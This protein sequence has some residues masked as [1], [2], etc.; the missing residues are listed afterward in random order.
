MGTQK[1]FPRLDPAPAFRSLK[2]AEPFSRKR[3]PPQRLCTVLSDLDRALWVTQARRK[4]NSRNFTPA[5]SKSKENM[6]EEV[7]EGSTLDSNKD[8]TSDEI[9]SI[10]PKFAQTSGAKNAPDIQSQDAVSEISGAKKIPDIQSQ[11]AVS[12]MIGNV[13]SNETLTSVLTSDVSKNAMDLVRNPIME[14]DE[15]LLK[16]FMM[17]TFFAVIVHIL[18]MAYYPKFAT[19]INV[20][21]F[22]STLI[23]F[24][25]DISSI[26]KD[27][28][29][30]LKGLGAILSNPA[31]ARLN[32]FKIV[33]DAVK[34]FKAIQ[35]NQICRVL[36]LYVYLHMLIYSIRA[37]LKYQFML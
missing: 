29:L 30:F 21:F 11:D 34:L 8:K 10:V 5:F 19:S 23:T 9:Q 35:T 26:K 3:S 18:C 37:F 32:G 28:E 1:L 22:I 17:I 15:A 16:N 20:I 36:T 4:T 27:S 12:N 25:N 31:L 14:V 2:C 24:H 33:F 13:L 6:N 7:K